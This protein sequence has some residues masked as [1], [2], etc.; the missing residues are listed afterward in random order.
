MTLNRRFHLALW[1]AL[2]VLAL[3]FSF[4]QRGSR[5]DPVT[6]GTVPSADTNGAISPKDEAD[7][8]HFVIAVDREILCRHSLVHGTSDEDPEKRPGDG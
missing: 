6:G 1:G 8:L 4:T 2:P 3:L 5:A 7:S